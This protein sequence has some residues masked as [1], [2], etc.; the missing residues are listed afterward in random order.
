MGNDWRPTTLGT[1]LSFANGKTSP[2][3]A[4]GLQYPVYGSN[5]VIGFANDTNAPE[6][7]IVIGRVGSYCG[8][9][10]FS[11]QKCWVTDNAIRA[12]A[13]D[14]NDA[15]FLFYLLSK[16]DLNRWRG[17]SG[18]P[19]LNQ[20]ILSQIAVLVPMPNEQHAIAYILGT[21]DDK[22][23]LNQRLNE[24]L[25]AIVQAIFKAWFADFDPVRAKIDGRWKKGQSLL[26]LPAD[27]WDFFP[28][29]FEDSELGEIP[30]GWEVM[31]AGDA[32]EAVGGGTPS[33]N[34]PD[35]W[36]DGKY[37]W[38][39]PKDLSRLTAP[40]LLDTERKI[41]EAGLSQISSG[42]LPSGTVLMSS[43]APV[44]YLAVTAVP[45]AI[46]QGFIGM[47]CHGPVSNWYA[48]NWCHFKMDEI[49]QRAS[50][51][52]FAEISKAAF[53]PIFMLVPER[54]VM[55][56]FTEKVKPFYKTIQENLEGSHTLAALRDTVLPK[57]ISGELRVKDA[58]RF[59]DEADL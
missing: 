17:G 41:T 21:L 54:N 9:L 49:K 10:Y 46:N 48:L 4:D 5:G 12:N 56:A 32:L 38:A 33:T 7:T 42:L 28:D 53:R 18:Q 51:T 15:R 50:G 44:G 25:E 23:E 39:T 2:E 1:V 6:K 36:D 37:W 8:S 13:I 35:Y 47:V 29:T 40:I 34:E 59:I 14:G 45:V 20:T 55:Q 16:L 3:R 24:T 26:G 57:L 43:R 11:K 27:L 52:T 30:R 31:R 22:I 19:L 58:E